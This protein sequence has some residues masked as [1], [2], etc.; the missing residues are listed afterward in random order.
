MWGAARRSPAKYFAPVRR[1]V[2]SDRPVCRSPAEDR[3]MRIVIPPDKFKGCL[4]ARAVA[5]A[6]ARGVLAA[7]PFAEVDLCPVADGGEG[8]VEAMVA[9]TGGRIETC[10]VTGPLP[11]MRVDAAFG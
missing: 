2:S 9:A 10:R 1:R 7:A 8:T 3:R 6:L 5:E 4:A 11:E